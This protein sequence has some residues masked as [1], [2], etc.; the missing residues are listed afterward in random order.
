MK[1]LYSQNVSPE[2]IGEVVGKKVH[3]NKTYYKIQFTGAQ[4]T[5]QTPAWVMRDHLQSAKE[6]INDYNKRTREERKLKEPHDEKSVEVLVDINS[7]FQ[8]RSARG[9]SPRQASVQH[10]VRAAPPAPAPAVGQLG[11]YSA[12]LHSL[13]QQSAQQ[14]L[15][16]SSHMLRPGQLLQ[17]ASLQQAAKPKHE[18]EFRGM[19]TIDVMP[20]YSKP[21]AA[22]FPRV[23]QPTRTLELKGVNYNVMGIMGH[24]FTAE[25]IM[26]QVFFCNMEVEHGDRIGVVL[27]LQEMLDYD[28]N[29]LQNY[30]TLTNS[31]FSPASG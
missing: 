23:I 15:A 3:G 14:V 8:K 29:V 6:I 16:A 1:P 10:S 2:M 19:K 7:P 11:F 4:G 31:S 18:D 12:H 17:A 21:T 24:F 28:V 27:T 5:P 30:V 22:G 13:T 9:S 25:T 26:F 20:N